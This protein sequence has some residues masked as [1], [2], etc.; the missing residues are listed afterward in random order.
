MGGI[1]TAIRTGLVAMGYTYLFY[2]VMASVLLPWLYLEDG[3]M[4]WTAF[5]LTS[6]VSIAYCLAMFCLYRLVSTSPGYMP[7]NYCPKDGEVD[8]LGENFR[9]AFCERCQGHTP[10]RA[11]HC[12]LCDRCVL[13]HEFH[14]LVYDVCVGYRNHKAYM[15][16]LW[17]SS[18][19]FCMAHVSCVV[20]FFRNVFLA[21]TEASY[22]TTCVEQEDCILIFTISSIHWGFGILLTVYHMYGLGALMSNTT[23]AEMDC[24]KKYMNTKTTMEKRADEQFSGRDSRNHLHYNKLLNTPSNPNYLPE[25]PYS[26]N[27]EDT[28]LHLEEVYGRNLLLWL[29]PDGPPPHTNGVTFPIHKRWYDLYVPD[30]AHRIRYRTDGSVDNSLDEEEGGVLMDVP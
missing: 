8:P 3:W 24:Y 13:K 16:Y 14:C 2:Q 28:R 10:Q 19:F 29:I 26:L 30:G 7:K 21:E 27:M 4:Y 11:I 22:F 18:C 12:V 25:W 6:I 9:L 15:L 1:S 20:W 23:W 17:N 5:V